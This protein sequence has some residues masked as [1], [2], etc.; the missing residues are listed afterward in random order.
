VVL[1]QQRARH[2][3]QIE[4]VFWTGEAL[5]RWTPDPTR[6]SCQCVFSSCRDSG[7]VVD[8]LPERLRGLIVA[9]LAGVPTA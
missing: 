4:D 5:G 8:R 9:W 6:C 7:L 1:A 2:R 3:G